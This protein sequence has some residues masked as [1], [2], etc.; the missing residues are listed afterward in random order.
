M[1]YFLLFY[2]LDKPSMVKM[3]VA[4]SSLII[5][6]VFMAK[7]VNDQRA[8]QE[9][10]ISFREAISVAFLTFIIANAVYCVF[11]F[12]IMK[13]DPE[14]VETLKQTSIE[15]YQWILQDQNPE[16]IKKS[17]DGFEVNF[18]TVLLSFARGAINGF[19]LSL[20]IAGTMRRGKRIK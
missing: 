16:E 18:S 9:D 7:A 8:L 20:L 13:S 10:I 15:F 19:I 2:F 17:F 14:L 12:F 5:Y 1:L 3:W 6:T 4:A 11:Y